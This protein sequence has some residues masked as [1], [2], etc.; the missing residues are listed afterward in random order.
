MNMFETLFTAL[1]NEPPY[2]TGDTDPDPR[3]KAIAVIGGHTLHG[4]VVEAVG[5]SVTLEVTDAPHYLF[6]PTDAKLMVFANDQV[7]SDE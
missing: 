3:Q 6:G 4:R 5:D 2:E 7:W 1:G